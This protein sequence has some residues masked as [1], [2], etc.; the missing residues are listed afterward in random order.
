M[1]LTL[2]VANLKIM[3][4][5]RQT[6]FWALAFPLILVTVFG[7]VDVNRAGSADLAV[8]DRARTESSLEIRKK[9]AEINYLDLDTRYVTE[10]AALEALEDGDLEYL[11]VI[12]KGV[13]GLPSGPAPDNGAPEDGATEN[14][15]AVDRDTGEPVSLSLYYDVNDDPGNQL[16]LGAISHFVD[17]ENIRLIGRQQLLQVLPKEVDAR[18]VD[19]FDVLLIG[20]VGMG[21]MT[22]SIILI[23]V[24]ISMYRNQ[25]ILKRMLV[26]PLRVRNYF[27]SEI[28]AHLLLSLV[29]ASVVIGVG[30]FVFGAH[31]YGNV[32]WIFIIVAFANT[33]FLNIG[34]IISAWV[35]S[36][37]AASGMGNAIAI[38]M[39][40]FSGTFF[41]TTLL[42][43]F[44]PDVMQALP[45]TPMLDAMRAVAIDELALWDV[46][47]ELAMLGGWLL[48]SSVV[49]IRTFRFG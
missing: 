46:W 40:F 24:K 12:P 21:M 41:P 16:V 42:P 13:A 35:N 29:Q 14:G 2:L 47:R 5:D 20:L 49:A 30:V 1:M 8:I 10:A 32:L 26:T 36:P 37:R 27:A 6:L 18:K 45:L 11:L 25:S 3:V 4:R 44:L 9:L 31:I 23:A 15:E 34:F 7:L 17:E 28:I 22:N 48:F 33:I 38:P 19:Y 43:A 39:L